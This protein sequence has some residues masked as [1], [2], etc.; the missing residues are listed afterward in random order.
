MATLQHSTHTVTIE[1]PFDIAWEYISNWRKQ[2]EWATNFVQSAREADGQ[3]YM[4]TIFGESP[5]DWRTNQEL[6][7]IDI[8]SEDNSVTPTRLLQLGD[9]LLYIFTFSMP[10][11][12]PPHVLQEGQDNM[13]E[14]LDN[15]KQIVEELASH[16][17]A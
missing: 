1:A 17:P 6:G 16:Q 9:S 14:E 13:D 15:L 10:V 2:P 4:T 11:D 8:V 5:I 3:V 12:V 7:T